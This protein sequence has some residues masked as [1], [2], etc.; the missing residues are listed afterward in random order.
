MKMLLYTQHTSIEIFFAQMRYQVSFFSTERMGTRKEERGGSINKGRMY[1]LCPH[2]LLHTYLFFWGG[3]R[4]QIF[5]R[6]F[7]TME[8]IPM[9]CKLNKK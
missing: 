3:G 1:I 5:V 4:I 8:F 6:K 2:V 9:S 7:Y